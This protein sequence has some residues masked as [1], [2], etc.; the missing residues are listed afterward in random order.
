MRSGSSWAALVPLVVA[1]VVMPGCTEEVPER[2][3]AELAEGTAPLTGAPLTSPGSISL[4]NALVTQEFEPMLLAPDG[5]LGIR[6]YLGEQGAWRARFMALADPVMEVTAL[7]APV[8][9]TSMAQGSAVDLAIPQL[10]R[11]GTTLYHP[12]DPGAGAVL[13]P[14]S[15]LRPF[16]LSGQGSLTLDARYSPSGKPFPVNEP[17]DCLNVTPATRDTAI[18]PGGPFECY[19]LIH[20]QPYVSEG[21]LPRGTDVIVLT[22]AEAVVVV[23]ARR[24]DTTTGTVARDTSPSVVAAQFTSDVFISVSLAQAGRP[25]FLHALEPSATADGRLVAT[26]RG[27]WTYNETPW[28]PNTWTVQR[29]F[30]TLFDD[31]RG[32]VEGVR[33]ICRHVNPTTGQP[34]CTATQYEDFARVYPVA[35]RPIFLADGSRPSDL[36]FGYTWITPEGTDVLCRPIQGIT[37]ALPD[38][39]TELI[40][41]AESST[42]MHFSAFGQHTGWVLRRLDSTI[43]SRR[44][45][46]E[47]LDGK[48]SE[49]KDEKD[50]RPF[51]P[52]FL[53][54]ATGFWAENRT[55][56][57]SSLPIHRQWPLFQF[58]TQSNGIRD[59]AGPQ[60]AS[61]GLI[62]EVNTPRYTRMQYWE[63]S[64]SCSI[65]P[66]CLLHL[67]M[68]EL[69]Y[70]AEASRLSPPVLRAL[71]LTQDL[72]SN[73]DF[74]DATGNAL[75]QI[76]PYLGRL[77]NGARFVGEVYG[78]LQDERYLSGFRGTAISMDAT[79]SVSVAVNTVDAPSC[80]RNKGCLAGQDFSKGFT[81]EVAFLLLSNPS[82]MSMTLARHY[83]LWKLYIENGVLLAD[84]HYVSSTTGPRILRLLGPSVLPFSART[85][86]IATQA[87]SWR[88]VALRVAPD[89]GRVFLLVNG[90]VVASLELEAGAS[91][92]ATAEAGSGDILKV[93]PAGGCLGCP[94]GEVLFMDELVFH[95]AAVPFEEL[96]ASAGA[97]SGRRDFLKPDD[98]ETLLAGYFSV[99]N[100]RGLSLKPGG[101]PHFVRKDDLRVPASFSPFL[102]PGRAAAFRQ[103][104]AVGESLFKSPVLSTNAAGVSQ[105]QG[106]TGGTQPCTGEPLSC[107]TCHRPDKAFTDGRTTALGVQPVPLNVPTVVNRVFGTNQFFARRSQD[108]LDLAL[109]P[110]VDP[111]E[112]NGNLDKILER[113]NTGADQASLRQGFVAV[114]GNTPVT[115]THLEQALTAYQLVQIS[116]DS[117]GEAVIAA[118][119]PVVDGQGNLLRPE[120]IRLGKELFEGKA[121]CSACHVGSNLT[122][123]LA[124]DTSVAATPAAFKTP[125]L[126]EVASTA[127][128]FHDGSRAT[129]RE[130]LDFY[131]SGGPAPGRVR[132]GLRMV[133]PELRPLALAEHE[134]DALE[135]YLMTLRNAGP[136]VTQGFAGLAFSDHGPIP[137]MVCVNTYEPEHPGGIW[138]D[139][140]LCAP[141]DRGFVWS[142]SGPVAGMRCTAI[143]EGA[144]PPET[145]WNDNYLCVPGNS[146]LQLT[147][148][149]AGP[150]FGKAC[151]RFNDSRDVHFWADNYLCYDEPLKL[152]FSAKGPISGMA[153]TQM[154]E[155][156]DAAHGWDDNY[157]CANKDVGMRW[158]VG[159]PIS[160]MRCTQV[161]E[162]AEAPSTTWTDNFLCVPP[163]ADALFSWS[164][165]GP[166]PG[167][168]CAQIHEPEDPAPWADNH[169]CYREEPLV[170]QF[171]VLGPLAGQACTFVGEGS[172][173]AGGWLDNYFCANRDIGMQWSSVGP[174]AGRR[175]TQVTESSEPVQTAWHD[176]FLCLPPDSPL[177]FEWSEQGPLPGRTCA[178]WYEP[179]D[180][181]LWSDNHLC[182]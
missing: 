122:D 48:P 19:R 110:V 56:Q 13:Y 139:N 90:V 153:C 114:Y 94:S 136:V 62:P 42:G 9:K 106:C 120:L 179:S 92:T 148:S 178:S 166:L 176:N 158:S 17:A 58:M 131:N 163:A 25:F 76:H 145:T 12:D 143:N 91:L 68:N 96:A 140:Y 162:D 5:R 24:P 67:P 108:L 103:L 169:L 20:F 40:H 174:I 72:S 177:I 88:H 100:P 118:G 32:D 37:G 156:L 128:Y 152:R 105:V 149:M 26:Q 170:L 93:G 111:R 50:H 119:K 77:Q 66:T 150:R 46:P 130:V 115:R 87:V 41:S 167:L 86:S 53:N 98:A 23:D 44:F 173:A 124:H 85:A 79:G 4:R 18:A 175:C 81:A 29:K 51:S 141:Q 182:R 127:P 159:G 21:N 75:P 112:L 125:T 181:Q 157:L 10:V 168:S 146:P 14:D 137:G 142:S 22:Q 8:F 16:D 43:N 161:I 49:P 6:V 38:A 134:L 147:W 155:P 54:T 133:D 117:L 160:G 71:K 33:S 60:Y 73:T 135:A 2:P 165:G 47:A 52:V 180:P 132:D 57:G 129:L 36:Y 126:W 82:A 151:V 34:T 70:D 109:E 59:A 138:A 3:Q 80:R 63:T 172:D 61:L 15:P 64:F 7:G 154:N 30:N 171:S 164:E 121:R 84:V 107:A 27:L 104:V 116:V 102:Q 144:E 28:N 39:Y 35:A 99:T 1:C 95:S 83:G 55:P 101:F 113:I 89:E 65:S 11:R 123:E 45:N 78:E 74:L 69:F 31:V 97:F